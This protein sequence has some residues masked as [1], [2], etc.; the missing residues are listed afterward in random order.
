MPLAIIPGSGLPVRWVIQNIATMA[1][2]APAIAVLVA[3]TANCTS[4]AAKVDAALKPNQPNSRMKV[5]SIAIGMWC[6]G[7]ARGLPSLSNLPMRAPITL[8]PVNA[9]TPPTACTTPEPAK[10]T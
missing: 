1:P 6:P 8:A 5:P 7:M 4:V 9:A 3:T 10:S 2:K